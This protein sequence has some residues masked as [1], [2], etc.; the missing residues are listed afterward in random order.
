MRNIVLEWYI[1]FVLYDTEFFGG[2][3]GS[4]STLDICVLENTTS[5]RFL[6][7]ALL[8]FLEKSLRDIPELYVQFY[9]K[10]AMLQYILGASVK[11]ELDIWQT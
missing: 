4:V 7:N 8:Q 11:Q 10:E 6:I 9:Q 3:L 2:I 1:V 5:P